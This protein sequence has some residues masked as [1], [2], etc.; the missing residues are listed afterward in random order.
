VIAVVL[1]CVA[2]LNV[3]IE[4]LM[5]AGAGLYVAAILPERKDRR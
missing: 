5:L 1:V 3:L 4:L 2:V